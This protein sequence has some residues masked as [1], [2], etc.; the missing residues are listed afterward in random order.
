M[1]RSSDNWNNDKSTSDSDGFGYSHTSDGGSEAWGDVGDHSN[2]GVPPKYG[3]QP[4]G[5]SQ[6]SGSGTSAPKDANYDV[7]E[8]TESQ[9]SPPGAS[10]AQQGQYGQTQNGA[11][12]YGQG[13]AQGYGASQ[14]GQYQ[15]PNQYPTQYGQGQQYGQQYPQGQQYGQQKYD[16]QQYPGSAAYGPRAGSATVGAGSGTSGFPIGKVLT[17]ITA[18]VALVVVVGLFFVGREQ[19]W[20]ATSKNEAS[21]SQSREAG[22][23]NGNAQNPGNQGKNTTGGQNDSNSNDGQTSGGDTSNGRDDSS[24]RPQYL[25]LPSGVEPA[26]QAAANNE[27]AGNLNNV[28]VMGGVTTL[29]FARN[30]RDAFVRNYLST[31][32]LNASLRDV[33]SPDPHRTYDMNC[34]DNGQYVRCDGGRNAI[35]IIS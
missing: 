35:V 34:V 12:E 6:Q 8:T 30:V 17:L 29:P 32:E 31:G 25:N 20:F 7:T 4:D 16:Q 1:P 18:V 33:Y 26:N 15:Q 24:G 5:N 28:Y 27:P 19:G 22:Q 9:P 11:Q 23:D 10:A 2:G 13:F 3:Y 21:S 14:Q